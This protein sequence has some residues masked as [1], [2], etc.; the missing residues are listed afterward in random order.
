MAIAPRID[1]ETRYKKI[2]NEKSGVVGT[3]F[4]K[5]KFGNIQEFTEDSLDSMESLGGLTEKIFTTLLETS[6]RLG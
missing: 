2:F 4:T 1:L 5:N 3:Q 6:I